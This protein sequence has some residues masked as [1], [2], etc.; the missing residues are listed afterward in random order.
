MVPK[1]HVA[2]LLL[3]VLLLGIPANL[4]LFRYQEGDLADPHRS[5]VQNRSDR[6]LSLVE[7]HGRNVGSRFLLYTWLGDRHPD[8]TVVLAPGHPLVSEALVGLGRAQLTYEQYEGRVDDATAE[9]LRADAEINDWF[10]RYRF[11][12]ESSLVDTGVPATFARGDFAV[13]IDD[14]SEPGPLWT[15]WTDQLVLLVDQEI[16]VRYELDGPQP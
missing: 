1:R 9:S 6:L 3:A 5:L 14:G 7:G 11:A 16:A 15:Y 4:A 13:L 8:A 10:N 12:S 2:L